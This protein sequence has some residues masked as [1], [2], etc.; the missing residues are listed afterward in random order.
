MAQEK[1]LSL[2]SLG[3]KATALILRQKALS[4]YYKNPNICLQCKNIIDVKD[5]DKIPK[6]KK[7]KFCN[8]S[9]LALYKTKPKKEK[10]FKEK[11][12]VL[13]DKF[14]TKKEIFDG[15]K[16]WQSA[17]GII[18]KHARFI[19][20]NSEKSKCCIECGYEKHYE[21]CHIKSVSKFEDNALIISDINNIENLIALCPNHH[22]E[23]D[24]KIL[25]IKKLYF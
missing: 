6:V 8:R 18:Q 9:C 5:G 21:V 1:T 2:Q 25:F 24:N 13:K 15:C 7:K 3:G 10:V 14:L 16:S 4:C 17:R 12:Q 11:F 22:W 19:Y 23:F 20:N